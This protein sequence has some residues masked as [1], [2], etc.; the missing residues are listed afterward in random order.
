MVQM[1]NKR[2][3]SIVAACGIAL[4]IGGG[5]YAFTASNTVQP[6]PPVR[7]LVLFRDTR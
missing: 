5:A 7:E 4:A 6:R 1:R 3:L 2:T